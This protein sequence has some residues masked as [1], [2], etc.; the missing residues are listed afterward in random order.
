[1]TP[2]ETIDGINTNPRQWCQLKIYNNTEC[3][4]ICLNIYKSIKN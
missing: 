4:P 3:M 1:M 2:L